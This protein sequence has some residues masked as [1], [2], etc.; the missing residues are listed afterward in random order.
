LTE[1]RV[2]TFKGVPVALPDPPDVAAGLDA[3]VG[4]D[5]AVVGDDAAVVAV[6]F[7]LLEW[8]L[9]PQAAAASAIAST[10]MARRVG[11]GRTDRTNLSFI[12]FYP[13]LSVWLKW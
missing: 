1:A 6:V 7:E 11:P 12:V 10:P 8:L 9:D 5:A 3:E 4:L 2:I 13:P